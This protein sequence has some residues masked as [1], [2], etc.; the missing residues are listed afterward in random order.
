MLACPTACSRAQLADHARHS[1]RCHHLHTNK[2]L[3]LPLDPQ[4]HTRFICDHCEH[5]ILGIGRTSTQTTLASIETTVSGHL[6]RHSQSD[7]DL[8]QDRQSVDVPP[9][10]PPLRV[11]TSRN[12]GQLSTIAEGISTTRQSPAVRTRPNS[13]DSTSERSA[14]HDEAYGSQIQENREHV[15]LGHEASQPRKS[16]RKNGPP[17]LS[18]TFRN[19]GSG[20]SL[21]NRLR[22]YLRKPMKFDTHHLGLHIRLEVSRAP[23]FSS[24]SSPPVSDAKQADSREENKDQL[25]ATAQSSHVELSSRPESLLPVQNTQVPAYATGPIQPPGSGHPDPVLDRPPTQDEKDKRI[26]ERRQKAT[27][28]RQAELISKCECR[29]GCHCRNGSV[30]SDAASHGHESSDRSIQIP[31]HHLHNLLRANSGSSASRSSSSMVRNSFLTAMG[32]HLHPE[33][34]NRSSDESTNPG[35]DTQQALNDR[36]SQ[37]STAYVRSNVSSI[38]LA[39]RRPASLRR[40]NTTPW[41]MPR[42]SAEGIRP[43]LLQVLQNADVPDRSQD[44]VSENPDSPQESENGSQGNAEPPAVT[45]DHRERLLDGL[46]DSTT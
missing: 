16:A 11:D 25:S 7:A 5:P 18:W 13:G 39:S 32:S 40:S 9:Q 6:V 26:R 41:S 14:S 42:H 34:L 17:S 20:K 22:G 38:S 29:S 37:T 12:S 31:D 30:R 4:A 33:Q 44:T 10:L 45:P 2:A 27:L 15:I 28:K 19:R 24:P 1:N 36:L 46:A 35:I 43:D 23:L 3:R 21:R 8:G